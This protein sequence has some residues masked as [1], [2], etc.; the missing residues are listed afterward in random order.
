MIQD[1]GTGK[2]NITTW[3]TFPISRVSILFDSLTGAHIYIYQSRKQKHS[4]VDYSGYIPWCPKYDFPPYTSIHEKCSKPL[5]SF[6]LNI[7]F[8]I[9]TRP[10]FFSHVCNILYQLMT[11][12]SLWFILIK[13]MFG[14]KLMTMKIN[15]IEIMQFFIQIT[16]NRSLSVPTICL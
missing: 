16:I 14:S 5:I 12:I 6:K 11:W 4:V 3:S 8:T 7:F 9:F 2:H 15:S 13:S 10:Q 1:K